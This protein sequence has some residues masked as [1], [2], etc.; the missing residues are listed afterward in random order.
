MFGLSFFSVPYCQS[1]LL[2]QTS[3]ELEAMK[4]L[5]GQLD[6]YVVAVL[7]SFLQSQTVQMWPHQ[8]L[9]NTTHQDELSDPDLNKEEVENGEAQLLK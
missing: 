4:L 6:F 5:V 9:R 3:D 2:S 7:T 8:F 1:I